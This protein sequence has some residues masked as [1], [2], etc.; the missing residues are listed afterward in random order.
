MSENRQDVA[1]SEQQAAGITNDNWKSC[2]IIC[3]GILEKWLF[4]LLVNA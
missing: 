2:A 1:W 4:N 3:F